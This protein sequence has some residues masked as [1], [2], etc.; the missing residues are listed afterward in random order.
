MS[1]TPLRSR[2][3]AHAAIDLGA[4][5]GRVIVGVLDGGR[6]VM[7]EVHRFSHAARQLGGGL[8]WDVEGLWN[9]VTAGL[10]AAGRWARSN[11]VPLRSAGVDTWGVDVAL[12]DASGE[13]LAPPRCYRDA[14]HFAALDRVV[15]T[16]GARSLYRI[17]GTAP[18]FF[19]T[20]FQLVA[21][22]ESEPDLLDRARSMLFMPDYF[23]W[24]LS[25]TMSCEATIA[26]TSGMVD[27][28]TGRWAKDLL[29]SLSLP[30]AMLLPIVPCGRRLGRIVPSLATALGLDPS[31]EIVAPAGHDTASAVA[32]VP[33]EGGDRWAYLSS[34]TWSLM[35]IERETP[36][37]SDGA[38][39]ARLT[40]EGGANGSVRL[41]RNIVGLWM[42]QEY[43][44]ELERAGERRSYEEL[45]QAAE[46]S[47]PMR[48]LVHAADPRFHEPG[49][50]SPR[51]AALARATGEPEPTSIGAVVRCALESL[52]LEY[53]RTLGEIERLAD[54]HVDTLHVVGGGS[55][56]ELLNQ[57]T[58]DATGRR[59]I[60][61]P[62]EATAAGN[63][64]VQAVGLGHLTF[65]EAR[66]VVRDSFSPRTFLPTPEAAASWAAARERYDS[67]L[68]RSTAGAP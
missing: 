62:A 41:L 28:R 13:L 8:V 37:L 45:T 3:T 21:M 67:I 18:M 43:R 25:G 9:D 1:G 53:A 47:E 26:S 22:R 17:S 63:L 10:H 29:E 7:Q 61:G 14:R 15:A 55:H 42:V 35:G 27:A 58:A 48:T 6:L 54:R 11:D 5:S 68:S 66:A 39:D 49:A 12:L 60:A 65:D 19:N 40:N 38:C 20:I 50:M 32:A 44:R 16:R 4:E 33:T 2:P 51:I 46:R 30:T 64:L 56:N 31:L 23:H 59:V 34:G 52:A 24:R 57:M 36:L